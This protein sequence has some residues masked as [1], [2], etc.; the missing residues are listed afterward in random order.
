MK[1]QAWKEYLYFSR[2]ERAAVLILLLITIT[3]CLLPRWVKT[4]PVPPRLATVI[5]Q[6]SSDSLHLMAAPPST[7]VRPVNSTVAKASLFAFNP[8]TL[9]LE[10]WLQLGLSPKVAHTI[11]NYRNKGGH[12]YKPDDI[13][14]I[15]G[16]P[17]AEASR[18]L[19]YIQLPANV[20]VAIPGTPYSSKHAVSID[21]NTAT[22]EDW[23]RF[24][25]IGEV[26]SKRI[27]AF[28][29][30][31]GG[32]TSIDQVAQTYGIKDSVFLLMKPYLQLHS[33]PSKE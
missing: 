29:N 14:K 30:S 4:S 2:K 1:T 12:F 3:C 17:E 28:R 21:I 24:P 9:P 31:V 33:I 26:L 20:P 16:L 22:A 10:G 15:Y 13:R 23:K 18:L 25:G 32:F 6:Q 11:I 5:L 8:N 27:V 7:E 19:P